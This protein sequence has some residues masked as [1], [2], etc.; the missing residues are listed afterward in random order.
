MIALWSPLVAL[1]L[2]VGLSALHAWYFRAHFP[3]EARF[4]VKLRPP[5]PVVTAPETMPLAFDGRRTN[6]PRGLT[7][8]RQLQVDRSAWTI[9]TKSPYVINS[10]DLIGET[11]LL[12]AGD[13]Q[14]PAGLVVNAPL[15][16]CGDLEVGDRVIL[17]RNIIVDGDI[18]A[19]KNACFLADVISRGRIQAAHGTKF[20]KTAAD[21]TG[22]VYLDNPRA[23]QLAT[24]ASPVPR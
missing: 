18:R 5:A 1:C 20:A 21:R 2:L 23:D 3:G 11:P 8:F 24:P 22:V 12:C 10:A 6:K 4:V 9:I 14:I 16:V 15:K 7:T 19:G 17:R 13:A